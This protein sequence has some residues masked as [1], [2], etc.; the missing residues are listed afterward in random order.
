[1]KR[2]SSNLQ[3]P[4]HTLYILFKVK[5]KTK[6]DRASLRG[7]DLKDWSI[8]LPLTLSLPSC[9]QTG[10]KLPCGEVHVARH[11][12]GLGP[13]AHRTEA[14]TPRGTKHGNSPKNKTGISY[15]PEGPEAMATRLKLATH[16]LTGA[17]RGAPSQEV[18]LG[19]TQIPDH[20]NCE[21]TNVGFFKILHQNLYDNITYGSAISCQHLS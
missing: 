16:T 13:P 12:G 7:L 14:L 9:Q 19:C 17:F 20:R 15:S 18:Q 3:T 5:R 6:G 2:I 11:K 10:G 21:K 4:K 1:M 8:L